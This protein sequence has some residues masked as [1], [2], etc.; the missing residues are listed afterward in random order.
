MEEA[1]DGISNAGTHTENGIECVASRAKMRDG[2]EIFKC[3]FLFLKWIV[4][5][6]CAL[7]LHA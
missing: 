7:E 6:R 2:A 4:G 1:V 3:V 5:G